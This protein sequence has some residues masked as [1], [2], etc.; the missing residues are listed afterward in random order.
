M[1]DVDGFGPD[2]ENDD[3]W[4]FNAT[5]GYRFWRRRAEA[6]VGL[7]NI[8]DQDYR[9]LPLNFYADLPRE[10]TFMMRLRLHL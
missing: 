8:T 9:L 3:F 7:L 2:F 1:Q 6:S 10:R 5:A 4:Q